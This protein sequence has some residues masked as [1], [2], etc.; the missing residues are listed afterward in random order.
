MIHHQTRTLYSESFGNT[1]GY[2]NMAGWDIFYKERFNGKI[3]ELNGGFCQQGVLDYQ[4]V[5]SRL[6]K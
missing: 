4:M 3:I 1:L 6:S 5:S 2:S